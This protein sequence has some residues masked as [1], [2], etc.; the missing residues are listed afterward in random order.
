MSASLRLFFGLVSVLVLSVFQPPLLGLA[1][2]L[3][4]PLH[5]PLIG[6]AV[7]C[8]DADCSEWAVS[9]SM[10]PAVSSLCACA[11]ATGL[12]TLTFTPTVAT[13]LTGQTLALVHID[14]ATSLPEIVTSQQRSDF[15]VAPGAL[16]PSRCIT[17]LG[18][19]ADGT[20]GEVV[21]IVVDARDAHDNEIS[22]S[23]GVG[24]RRS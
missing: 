3:G 5:L 8:G 20:A 7:P 9:L 12:L 6:D 14:V 2:S 4:I 1:R 18:S 10:E 17:T 23:V 22:W 24:R 11:S 19:I 15:V 16:A 13:P 21:N